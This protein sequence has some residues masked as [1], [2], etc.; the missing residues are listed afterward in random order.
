M[1]AALVACN[2]ERD[3]PAR[4]EPSIDDNPPLVNMVDGM[5]VLKAEYAAISDPSTTKGIMGVRMR[6]GVVVEVPQPEVVPFQKFHQW[7]L[8]SGWTNIESSRLDK[9][10]RMISG[11]DNYKFN[12]TAGCFLPGIALKLTTSKGDLEVVVCLYCDTVLVISSTTADSVMLSEL[13]L[14]RWKAFYFDQF[15][16]R[17]PNSIAPELEPDKIQTTAAPR[18]QGTGQGNSTPTP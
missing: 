4:D 3:F 6:G 14:D 10:S 17:Q 16:M 8:K 7:D 12:V 18:H 9:L 11:L 15:V 5:Q 2:E 13:E 1:A